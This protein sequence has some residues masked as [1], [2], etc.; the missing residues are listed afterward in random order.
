[1]KQFNR[2]FFALL[3]I[4]SSVINFSVKASEYSTIYPPLHINSASEDLN[5]E[6]EDPSDDTD[7]TDDADAN[8]DLDY[9]PEDTGDVDE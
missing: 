6:D 2:L 5:R 9:N 3:L 8:E 7:D 4:M 1:M